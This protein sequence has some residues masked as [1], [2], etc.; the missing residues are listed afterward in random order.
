MPPDLRVLRM[1]A[2]RAWCLITVTLRIGTKDRYGRYP[3]VIVEHPIS[4][5]HNA[6]D[7]RERAHRYQQIAQWVT[8]ERALQALNEMA[9]DFLLRADQIQAVTLNTEERFE[10][11]APISFIPPH[12]LAVR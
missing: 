3:S 10:T 4:S 5:Y 1:Q 7:L 9:R 2:S 11:Q 8:D 12:G 6:N